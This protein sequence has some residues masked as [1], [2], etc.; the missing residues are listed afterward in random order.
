MRVIC[1]DTSDTVSLSP[2]VITVS[3]GFAFSQCRHV[4]SELL[5]TNHLSG[6]SIKDEREASTQQE[7]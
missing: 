1:M 7:L 5:I 3:V 4:A 2:S 6:A